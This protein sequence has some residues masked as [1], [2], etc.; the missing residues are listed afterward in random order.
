[1][2]WPSL[3]LFL[4][5]SAIVLCLVTVARF[6]SRQVYRREC[7]EMRQHVRRNYDSAA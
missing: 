6:F 5:V 2:R 7:E 4:V 3:L 1:M